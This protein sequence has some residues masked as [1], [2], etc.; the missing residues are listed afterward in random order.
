M[1]QQSLTVAKDDSKFKKANV[2]LYSPETHSQ[3]V[4]MKLM[5]PW[6]NSTSLKLRISQ[7]N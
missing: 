5:G 2:T 1:K 7:I 4:I 3:E 6:L